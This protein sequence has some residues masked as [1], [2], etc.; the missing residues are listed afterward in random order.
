MEQKELRI[1]KLKY[2]KNN[3]SDDVACPITL[4]ICYFNNTVKKN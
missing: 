1:S 3:E 2:V 4:S